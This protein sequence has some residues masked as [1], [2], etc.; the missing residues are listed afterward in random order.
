MGSVLVAIALFCQQNATQAFDRAAASA[1][2]K[3]CIKKV[4]A[5]VMTKWKARNLHVTS[6]DQNEYYMVL[7]YDECMASP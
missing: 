2:Q 4:T 6:T 5:C 1:D 7:D 3:A